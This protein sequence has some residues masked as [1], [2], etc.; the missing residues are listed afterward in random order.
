MTIK[1][2]AIT[3]TRVGALAA[4]VAISL[5]T[6]AFA[7][8]T[9]ADAWITTKVKVSLATTEG[10]DPTE[11]HVDTV[12]H[13][14]TLHGTVNTAAEKETA[15]R[16]AKAI[17]GVTSVRNLLQVVPAK[18]EVA[19]EAKD[20]DIAVRV[21]AALAANASLKDSTISVQSVNK[22]LVL[23]KGNAKSLSDHLTAIEITRSV[24]G[25][26]RVASEVQSEE[27]LADVNI[28]KERNIAVGGGMAPSA[29]SA[30]TDLYT[31]SMVKM[32]LLTNRDTPAM[33]INV[34]T[35]AGVVTLFG[36]VP[37]AESKAAAENEATKTAGVVS[38]KN[39]LQVVASA[40]QPAV[41]AKDDVIQAD[42]RKNLA[43]N[44]DLGK[45]TCEVKNCVARL[46]GTVPSGM[47]RVEA[48]QIARAT[49][50]VC[51]VKEDLTVQ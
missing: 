49:K 38:V 27:A 47:E 48:M 11:V 31:T 23:L 18:N 42:V 12:R 15:E 20:D 8:S 2:G 29:P 4:L 34:D 39:Q 35:R 1:T 19:V 3:R 43:G 9:P 21:S 26:R 14:V 24:S 51:S 17:E 33:D 36:V 44:A 7:M 28:W 41:E 37:T 32:A 40:R 6:P 16:T 50:G 45:V 30:S 46:T 25:V 5:A 10:V 13:E 22:G